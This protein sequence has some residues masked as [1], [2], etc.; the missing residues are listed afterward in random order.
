MKLCLS[1]S[2][3]FNFLCGLLGLPRGPK[4]LKIGTLMVGGGIYTGFLNFNSIDPLVPDLFVNACSKMM[5]LCLA[6]RF[7]IDYNVFFNNTS[8]C[9]GVY[10]GDGSSSGVYGI[11]ILN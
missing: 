11:L 3:L 1:V 4:L 5:S 8:T 6:V 9:F 10:L 2:S 7:L